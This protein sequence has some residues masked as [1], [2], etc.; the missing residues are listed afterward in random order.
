VGAQQQPATADEEEAADK[1]VA[2]ADRDVTHV[3]H[4][5]GEGDGHL[6]DKC[7]QMLVKPRTTINAYR[8]ASYFDGVEEAGSWVAL[9]RLRSTC[10]SPAMSTT[11]SAPGDFSF[12]HAQAQR[13][14]RI[15][16]GRAWQP[17]GQVCHRS[18]HSD[19]CAAQRLALPRVLRV[20]SR[21]VPHKRCCGGLPPLQ[22]LQLYNRTAG[23]LS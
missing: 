2:A 10:T 20:E 12:R 18:R 17:P 1:E 23:A 9:A 14:A 15:R 21:G 6:Q 16:R 19:R 7:A 13:G 5:D 11:A 8:V 22:L 3:L 4:I